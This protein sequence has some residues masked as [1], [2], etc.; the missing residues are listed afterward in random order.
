MLILLDRGSSG[1]VPWFT[2][3]FSKLHA[4]GLIYLN[5][6]C[7]N[8]HFLPMPLRLLILLLLLLLCLLVLVL[9]RLAWA[10]AGPRTTRS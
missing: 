7:L 10:T 2:D 9:G 3:G 8:L 5:W 4:S 6:Y 1:I